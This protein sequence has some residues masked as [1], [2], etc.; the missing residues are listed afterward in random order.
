MRYLEETEDLLL[1]QTLYLDH[2]STRINFIDSE[3]DKLINHA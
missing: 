3:F 2:K 1:N